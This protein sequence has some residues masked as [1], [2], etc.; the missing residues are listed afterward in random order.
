MK[1]FEVEVELGDQMV[2]GGLS[3]FPLT[4]EREA[5]PAYLTGPEA[6]EAGMIQVSELDPPEV[7]SLAIFNLALV[8]ILLVEGEMLVGGDQNRTMNVTVLC[9]PQVRT[10]VPVSCVEAGRWGKRR[11][12]SASSKHAPGSLRAAKTAN[13]EPRSHIASS[14][15]SDQGRIWDEVERQSMAHDVFSET[16]ALDDIQEEIED[17]LASELEKIRMV[18]GQ[19]GVICTIGEQVVGLDLFDKPSTLERYLRGIVAGHA[20]DARSQPSSA[21]PIRAIEHFLAQIDAAGRD[22]GRGVGLGE[23]IL[24]RGEVAGIGLMYE[25]SLVHLAAFPIPDELVE[26]G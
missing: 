4:G 6:F 22:A 21:D 24:L 1:M 16:S 5:G 25:S 9:P 18:P 10:V 3:V 8:P 26:A 14:R 7:P 19:I 15:R 11:V 17:R 23:E 13:L 20:L 12:V 2:I